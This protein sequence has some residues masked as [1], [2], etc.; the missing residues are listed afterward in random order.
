MTDP[1]P[2]LTPPPATSAVGLALLGAIVA[3]VGVWMAVQG[4]PADAPRPAVAVPPTVDGFRAD[5]W[6]LP[7]EPLLGFVEIPA[8]PFLMGSD[9]GTDA[10]A[11]DNE[12]WS[13]AAPQATLTLPTYLLGRYEVTVA[14][15]AAFVAD[16]GAGVDPAA[17]AGPPDHPVADVTWPEALAYCDWLDAALR[18]SPSTPAPLRDRLDAGWRVTLPTEA[19]WEKAAR[20]PEGRVYPWG[21]DADRRLAN[22]QSQATAPVGSYRCEA[23]L[24]GLADMSGNVWEWTRSPYQPYPFTDD[25]DAEGLGEDALWV[26]RG[27]AYTDPPRNVRGA[28]R[29]GADPGASRPFIGFRVALSPPGP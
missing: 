12:R 17:L 15:F 14:Q 29:G 16:T 19:Q 25:D 20:G 7:D 21:E 9:P 6:F 28:I 5:A 26:M 1:A 18:A 10:Q 2:A 13:P 8:G 11:F 23:C 4:P 24:Y 27:G 22:F 3:G